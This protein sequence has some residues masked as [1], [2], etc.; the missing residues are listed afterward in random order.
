M[1]ISIKQQLTNWFIGDVLQN[2]TEVERVKTRFMFNFAIGYFLVG[3]ILAILALIT[4][5][6]REIGVFS[7]CVSST[8]LVAPFILKYT[9][10]SKWT[11]FYIC[12]N[13]YLAILINLYLNAGIVLPIF[14]V[15]FVIFI[16][17]GR[18]LLDSFWSKTFIIVSLL[19][20]GLNLYL[21]ESGFPFPPTPP[22]GI[23]EKVGDIFTL[24]IGL[25]FIYYIIQ[26]FILQAKILREDLQS[27]NGKIKQ[28]SDA[29][30]KLN[31]Q[32]IEREDALL[33]AKEAAE[34]AALAKSSFLSTMS[35]EIRTPMNAVIGM[36][37]LLQETSLDSE[38]REY[39]NIVRASGENL[40]SLIND[41]LDFSKIDSGKIELESIIFSLDQAVTEA[42]DIASVQAKEKGIPIR[43][44]KAN[45]LPFYIE[46]D[47][48]RLRQILL[49]LLSNAVKFTEK[50]EILVRL[51]K[52]NQSD[53][54]VELQFEVKDRGIGIPESKRNRLFQAFTQI[55]AST[56]REYG[57]T[58]LGLV[59]SRKLVNILG[60]EI[61]V[62]SQVGQ[63]SSFFF[64][65][66]AKPAKVSESIQPSTIQDIKISSEIPKNL[67]IL[68]VED[69]PINQK[70]ADRIF[71]RL[72]YTIDKVANGQEAIRI[73]EMKPYD[74]V[75]MDIQMPVMDGIS[76]TK[77]RRFYEQQLA[78]PRLT[79]IAMTANAFQ[80]DRENC[81]EAG[82]DD[83]LSKPFKINDLEVMLQKWAPQS[84]R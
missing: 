53:E 29:Q 25:S 13:N 52:V 30:K 24:A 66:K 63:G 33:T 2:Q 51:S 23:A 46:S 20:F 77:I 7:I 39:L 3:N 74:L 73:M 58:G 22:K 6:Y 75:F 50:D 9:G 57:G 59:I 40:L 5:G 47:I 80:E 64:T 78:L 4:P 27:Q 21:L 42:I 35:H 61:W 62:E 72:G 12:L 15:I 69:N 28:I 1:I 71:Q 36:S 34:K 82:M 56:T 38:Q 48:T 16:L 14:P 81:F 10:G 41:I 18:F 65:I 19:T 32:L 55:D 67:K 68:L 76:A 37:S 8:Y 26:Q 84:V 49:N 43:F 54:Y 70:V 60:G 44:E 83:F 17:L 79:I 11:S 45:D 31:E